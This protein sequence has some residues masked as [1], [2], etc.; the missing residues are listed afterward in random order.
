M[1]GAILT[2]GFSEFGTDKQITAEELKDH[3]GPF[4]I[5]LGG[6]V[7]KIVNSNLAKMIEDSADPTEIATKKSLLA[8]SWA[9]LILI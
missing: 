1:V 6:I 8:G 9:F 7:W 2:A 4:N 5:T 3:K